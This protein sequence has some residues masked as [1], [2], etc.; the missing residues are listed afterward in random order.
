MVDGLRANGG[1]FDT[2]GTTMRLGR[3]FTAAD[4]QRGGGPA[5]PV[6]VISHRL[7]QRRFAGAGDVVGRTLS[8]DRVGYSIVA[9][10]PEGF[11]GPVAGRLSDVVIPLGMIGV[12]RRTRTAPGRSRAVRLDV[13]TGIS[14]S[15][16]AA[17]A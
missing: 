3:A 1:F 11:L 10:L 13:L 2:L 7:W 4:D 9:V 15:A 12:F 8:I 16:R 6:A 5:G 14:I 17:G